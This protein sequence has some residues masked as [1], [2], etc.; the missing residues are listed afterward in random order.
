MIPEEFEKEVRK[1]NWMN[2]EFIK[3]VKRMLILLEKQEKKIN[4]ML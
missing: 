4:E 3:E 2:K 1:L